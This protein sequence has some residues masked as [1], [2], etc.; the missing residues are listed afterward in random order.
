MWN[1]PLSRVGLGLKPPL[2]L[3]Q[4]ALYASRNAIT[5]PSIM[6]TISEIESAIERL[7]EKDVEALTLW[8]ESRRKRG[9]TKSVAEAWLNQARGAARPGMS[10]ADVM[11]LTRSDE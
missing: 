1:R 5:L 8:L 9:V 2:A 11:A 7:P 4:K 6:S 10:T 3:I